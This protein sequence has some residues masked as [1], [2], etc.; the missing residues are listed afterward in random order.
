M[1]FK[2]SIFTLIE[3][4]VV[5]AIIAIL[6]SMLLPALN[7]ARDKGKQVSCINN[8][9]QIGFATRSYQDDY[10]GFFPNNRGGWKNNINKYLKVDLS[11][12]EKGVWKCP[13]AQDYSYS[14]NRMAISGGDSWETKHYKD[15]YHK[16]P[17]ESVV[18]FDSIGGSLLFNPI[19]G[20]KVWVAY[21][22]LNFACAN[23]A[24]GHAAAKKP[25]LYR[26]FTPW[27]D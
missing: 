22:H 23:F 18:V 5:I 13:S 11:K 4:L 3:L 25:I 24:D 1:K 20:G 16:E 12:G 26:D 8:L 2:A 17:S 10:A 7:K 14:A 19:Q 9:R 6:A 27:K 21:R 15:S